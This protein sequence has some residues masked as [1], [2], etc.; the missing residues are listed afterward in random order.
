M[1]VAVDVEPARPH[2]GT[3]LA[4]SLTGLF[5]AIG[6]PER[7][8]N[9]LQGVLGHAFQFQMN[10]N[11]RAETPPVPRSPACRPRPGDNVSRVSTIRRP[12]QLGQNERR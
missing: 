9:W 10:P 11:G 1:N 5:E 8:M 4:S 7:D 12:I 2:S 6:H 3:T